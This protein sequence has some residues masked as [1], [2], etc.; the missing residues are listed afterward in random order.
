MI[1]VTSELSLEQCNDNDIHAYNCN[2]NSLTLHA[3]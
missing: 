2:A 1:T 3:I